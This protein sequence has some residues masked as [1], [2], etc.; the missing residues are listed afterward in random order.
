MKANEIYSMQ[1]IKE[2]KG[3][4]KFDLIDSPLHGGG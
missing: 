1:Q 2:D 4:S 3:N